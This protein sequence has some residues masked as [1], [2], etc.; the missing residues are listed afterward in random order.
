MACVCTWITK[1]CDSARLKIIAI[2]LSVAPIICS[3]AG[4]ADNPIEADS[5]VYLD[6][7]WT[8][9]LLDEGSSDCFCAESTNYRPVQGD[10][11]GYRMDSTTKEECCALCLID[12]SCAVGVQVDSSCWIRNATEAAGGHKSVKGVTACR[13]VSV[14]KSTSLTI[15]ASVPG[16]LIT[17]L[18]T[19]G[20]IGDPLHEVNFLNASLWSR[21][22]LYETTF[23]LPSGASHR[24]VFDGVKMGATI[25]V[26]G[27]VVGTTHDQFLRYVFP[28]PHSILDHSALEQ[29]L[30]VEF[31]A[32]GA[33]DCGGRWMACSGRLWR[34]VDG[35]LG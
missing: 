1:R 6:G 28:I 35:M 5:I 12:D 14:H 31:G 4:M 23:T 19:A 11:S 27:Q 16:D 7:P 30:E 8:A 3:T 29:T 17:D 2:V 21:P 25:K 9:T 32:P 24:L 15:N 22:W 20:L 33:I 10:L 18:E 26:N 13:R 34:A